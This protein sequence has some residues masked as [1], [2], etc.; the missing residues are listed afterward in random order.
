MAAAY[1]KN[2]IKLWPLPVTMPFLVEQ[3]MKDL[4]LNQLKL[5]ELLN[6]N[7]SKLSKILNGKMPPDISFLKAMHQKLGIDGNT[8]LETI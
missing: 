4:N 5:A 1:E 8:I 2:E 3:K 7:V 6:M